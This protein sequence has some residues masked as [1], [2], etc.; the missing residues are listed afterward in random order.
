MFEKYRDLTFCWLNSNE[1]IVISCDSCGGVG[2]KEKD[3]IKV[4]PEVVGYYT[5][6]VAL[7]EILAVKAHP[8]AIIN[9]LAVEMDSTG[10]EILKGINKALVAAELKDKVYI[11]GSTEENF[12][13]LQT[14]L[15]ITV[16]GKVNKENWTLPKSYRGDF[17][18]VIGIPKVGEEVIMDFGQE[19]L[20]LGRYKNLLK[21]PYINEILPVGSKGILFELQELA[22]SNNLSFRLLE[23]ITL[24]LNKSAGPA[25]CA[26]ITFNEKDLYQVSKDISLPFNIIG[27]FC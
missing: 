17:I 27:Q 5:T 18:A 21:N 11:T 8:F 3:Y 19:T 1:A 16:L 14:A 23:K 26:L 2:A 12:P 13:S 22:Q 20:L 7:M 6:Q 10:K 24:D 25:T 4:S 9:N 15:G